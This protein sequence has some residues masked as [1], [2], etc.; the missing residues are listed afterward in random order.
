MGDRQSRSG[1][2]RFLDWVERVGNKIPHP[3]I[4]F[5]YLIIALMII[6][7]ILAYANV[8][9]IHPTTKKPVVAK[10]LL[11]VEG[12]HWMLQ[13]AQKNFTDFAPLGLVLTML[14]GIGLA[15]QVG[16][17]S[18]F[19]RKTIYGAPTW[20]ISLAVMFIG[21]NGNIASDASIVVIPALAAGAYLSLGKNPLVGIAAAYAATC[22]GFSANV[23]IVGTDALL[24]G[25]TQEAVKIIDPKYQVNPAVNWYFMLASTLLFTVIG[26]L[27]TDRVIAPWLGKYEGKAKLRENDE[28]TPLEQ[29]GLRSAGIAALVFLVILGL[30]VLP[31]GAILRDPKSGTII[32]SPFLSGIVPI[33]MLFFVTVGVAYGKAVGAIKTGADVPRLMTEAVKTMAGYIVLVFVIGQFV[34]YFNWTNIGTILAVK[35]AEFLKNAGFTGFPLVIGIILISTFINL[36]IGSGSA[37]WSVLAPIFVPMMMLLGYSPAFTQVA[38]RIGDSSTNPISPLFPYFPIVLALAQQYDE[39]VGVGTIISMMLPY[40]LIFLVVWILQLG[41]WMA[42]NLPLGPGATIFM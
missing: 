22:A 7:A 11:T 13:N 40:S 4:L 42:L 18:A 8:S 31:K 10:S 1:L 39:N 23:L 20:A 41:V 9:V 21:I 25:I 27:I 2:Q 34:A 19:M 14:L 26:A 29:R 37:K 12:F 33:I 5:L 17:L 15:E 38:Y 16:L 35:G 30:L 36:F 32:P 3:F 6:S 28:L 24:A